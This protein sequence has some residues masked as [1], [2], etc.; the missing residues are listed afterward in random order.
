MVVDESGLNLDRPQERLLG[1]G[2]VVYAERY[3]G[4]FGRYITVGHER[5]A[6]GHGDEHR[7][8]SQGHLVLPDRIVR[9]YARPKRCLQ[10]LPLPGPER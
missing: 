4:L 6:G 9:R 7:G 10:L 5:P 3:D 1:E 2:T 8:N